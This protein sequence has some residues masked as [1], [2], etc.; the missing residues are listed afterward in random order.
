MVKNLIVGL[1]VFSIA[2]VWLIYFVKNQNPESI[3]VVTPAPTSTPTST[4]I[5]E[6]SAEEQ[7]R[8]ALAKKYNISP[9]T[10][11]ITISENTATHIWGNSGFNDGGGGGWFLA[12]KNG[13]KWIIVD[14]GNGIISCEKVAPYGFPKSM[15]PECVDNQ[16]KL[17]KY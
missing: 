3:I 1:C 10:I 13:S 9:N 12:F 7:I 14:D 5:P 11:D 16:G 2:A 15:V 8:T 6:L 17:I 4:P